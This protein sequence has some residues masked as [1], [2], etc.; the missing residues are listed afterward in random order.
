MSVLLGSM[1]ISVTDLVE[2][3]LCSAFEDTSSGSRQ[4]GLPFSDIQYGT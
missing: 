2:D 1:K 3:Q 4:K